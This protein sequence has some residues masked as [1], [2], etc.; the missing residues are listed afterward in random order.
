MS[1]VELEGAPTEKSLQEFGSLLWLEHT[2]FC[3]VNV[4]F[5]PTLVV[6]K[7][8]VVM[9]E[10]PWKPKQ[11]EKQYTV[12]STLHGTEGWTIARALC[13]VWGSELQGLHSEEILYLF[14]RRAFLP[15]VR[16]PPCR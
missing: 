10:L 5:S 14:S 9:N 16:F 1:A 3:V 8:L 12:L 6:G 11:K 2:H 4:D 7:G 15:G 13:A